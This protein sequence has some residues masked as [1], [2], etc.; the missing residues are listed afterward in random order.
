LG[1][2]LQ[3]WPVYVAYV[4]RLGY[5][6]RIIENNRETKIQFVKIAKITNKFNIS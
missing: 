3:Q 6:K 4:N 5:N 1:D 2:I